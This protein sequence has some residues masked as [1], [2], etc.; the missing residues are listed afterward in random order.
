[1]QLLSACPPH[2]LAGNVPIRRRR[3]AV[4]RKTVRRIDCFEVGVEHGLCP[5]AGI[6]HAAQVFDE[7]AEEI[8]VNWNCGGASRVDVDPGNPVGRS[9]AAPVRE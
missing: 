6:D 1:M 7:V 5:Q 2:C 8:L 4:V 3:V 9:V